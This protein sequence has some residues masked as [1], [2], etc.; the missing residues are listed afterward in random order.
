LPYFAAVAEE[1]SFQRA[2]Q[3]LNLAQSALSRRIQELEYDLGGVP[4][5]LRTARGVDL[6]PSGTLLYQSTVK[7]LAIVE[8]SREQI[9]ALGKGT[10]GHLRIGYSVG[11]LRHR[12][13]ETLLRASYSGM[14]G[15]SLDL[16]PVAAPDMIKRLRSGEI[17]MGIA[18]RQQFD[19]DFRAIPIE[20]EDCILA[21]PVS[22]HLSTRDRISC[23]DLES[24]SLI[25]FPHA[26][27]PELHRLLLESF[28]ETGTKPR[29]AYEA[30]TADTALRWV[31]T[32][33]GIT[34]V[35]EN[36]RAALPEGVIL[37]GVADLRLS[38]PFC[39]VWIPETVT[40]V[41][42]LVEVVQAALATEQRQGI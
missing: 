37:R 31:A 28:W 5:F 23:A 8:E 41:A 12:F 32:G 14:K 10:A 25:W 40:P 7:V 18:I 16:T 33:T 4:L 3:R 19:P 15:I 1:L 2:A 17:Q 26:Q 22:H 20:S 27:E 36:S 39:L 21:L 34:F 24:E 35:P 13:F 30:P 9:A 42:Q 29:I 6:T 11:V 38:F